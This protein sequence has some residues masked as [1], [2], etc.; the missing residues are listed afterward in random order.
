VA[1]KTAFITGATGF[2][3]GHVARLLVEQ[4][5]K[6]AALHRAGSSNPYLSG[7][8][9]DWRSGDLR[10]PDRVR[11]A[12][13][14]CAVVFHVAADYRL[15]AAHPGEIYANNVDGT[16]NV[17]RAAAANGVQRVVYTGSVGA[18][19]L[20]RDGTPANEDTPV[21]LKDM[22]G[23]YKRSKFL[24]E[25]KAEEFVRRGLPIVMVH[26]STPVG[27]G[28]HKPTPTGKIIVDFLNRRLPAYVD[29]GLNLVHVRDVAWGHLMALE[30][31]R[32]GEKYILGNCNLRLAEIFHLLERISGLPAP[33]IRLRHGLVLMLA[34]LN[35]LFS[36]MTGRE[37]RIPLEGV[38][39]AHRLMFF[40]ASRAVR[41]LG[42]PQT[43]VEQALEEAVAWYMENGYVPPSPG[44]PGLRK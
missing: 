43:P 4:N 42:L 44:T 13:A 34:H 27:A 21:A 3:G 33:R 39:M 24:A 36:R 15:W 28:D 16:V 23:H 37:P 25:R 40:D 26:P 8:D 9:L 35:A 2:V 14:G 29:T 18:L 10:D 20:N 6:V 5:W 19:G 38:R 1:G 32:P 11:R 22:V 17:L 12:M 41:E 30:K 31:G 7:V